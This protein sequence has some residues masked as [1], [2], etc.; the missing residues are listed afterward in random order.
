LPLL[1]DTLQT[2]ASRYDAVSVALP[3]FDE[4]SR[5]RGIAL[6]HVLD[7]PPDPHPNDAGHAV[8]AEAMLDAIP[9]RG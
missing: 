9:D 5:E 1:V 3:S 4:Q 8:I 7:T 6:T 2:V